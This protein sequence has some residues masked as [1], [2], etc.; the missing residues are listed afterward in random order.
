MTPEGLLMLLLIV[1]G[2]GGLALY[3][4]VKLFIMDRRER[5]V[6]ERPTRPSGVSRDD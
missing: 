3:L 4:R 6:N 5:Q 1:L 2:L